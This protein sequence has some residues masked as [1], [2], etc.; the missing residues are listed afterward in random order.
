MHYLYMLLDGHVILVKQ[1]KK[2]DYR[3][4][5]SCCWMK[6]HPTRKA[7]SLYAVDGGC[8]VGLCGVVRLGPY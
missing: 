7:A 3:V 1:I 2:M 8:L 5:I 6:I 4:L